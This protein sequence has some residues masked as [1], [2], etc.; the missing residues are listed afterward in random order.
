MQRQRGRCHKVCL[1]ACDESSIYLTATVESYPA[2]YPQYSALV[3][4]YDFFFVFRSFRQL[5]ARLLLAKQDELQVLE[6]QL[7]QLD[8]NEASPF[9]LG[10]C[11]ED[12]NAGRAALLS[13]VHLKLTEYGTLRSSNLLSWIAKYQP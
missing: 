13:Q 10:T 6:A 7:E 8:R 5:R 1:Y 12:S 3:S 4:S 2:G 9:F 11:R